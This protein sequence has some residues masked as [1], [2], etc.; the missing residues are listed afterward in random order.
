MFLLH[1]EGDSTFV[2]TMRGITSLPTSIVLSGIFRQRPAVLRSFWVASTRLLKLC[3]FRNFNDYFDPNM[4]SRDS[5]VAWLVDL[6]TNIFH[7][8]MVMHFVFCIFI[9]PGRFED[10]YG[11]QKAAGY[12]DYPNVPH[13]QIYLDSMVYCIS[14]MGG[15]GFGNIVPIANAEYLSACLVFT[16]GN[17]IYHNYF[18]D[19]ANDISINNKKYMQNHLELEK[20]KKFAQVRNLPDHLRQKIQYYFKNLRIPFEEFKS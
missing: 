17:S 11:W 3:R 20:C 8:M 18:A 13:W 16:I 15:M 10:G 5:K 2:T 4:L 6:L 9:L 12:F 14:N 1:T 7:F 19:F